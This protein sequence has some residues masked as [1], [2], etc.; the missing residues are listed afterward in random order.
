MCIKCI[1]R[2]VTRVYLVLMFF[3]ILFGCNPSGPS[4][5]ADQYSP[6]L[7]ID[8]PE[9]LIHEETY[10]VPVKV[11]TPTTCHT[12]KIFEEIIREQ[13][14]RVTPVVVYQETGN[15][16]LT[17]E[18]PYETYFEFKVEREDRYEFYFFKGF[19]D[20]DEPQYFRF[21]KDVIMP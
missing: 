21:N 20:N 4:I 19:D 6:I 12:F 14:Y 13:E 18:A 15:C 9:E 7:E 1:L 16:E 2:N 8:F 5:I 17:L 11:A 3:A 10:L